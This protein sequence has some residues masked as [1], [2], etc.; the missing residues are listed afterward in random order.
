M[1]SL[2]VRLRLTAERV[3]RRAMGAPEMRTPGGH[4]T[5]SSSMG[6]TILRSTQFDYLV[7]LPVL[8]IQ[9]EKTRQASRLANLSGLVVDSLV[10]SH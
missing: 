9:I 8:V 6:Y 5:T 1:L 2:F 3:A 7:V 10:V 4:D